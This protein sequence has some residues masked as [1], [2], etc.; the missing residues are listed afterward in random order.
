MT[1]NTYDGKYKIGKNLVEIFENTE[2]GFHDIISDYVP[3]PTGFRPLDSAISN[4]MRNGELVLLGGA[5][6]VGKTVA[7]LQI[8]RNIASLPD[9][10]AYYL[11]YEHPEVHLMHRLLCLESVDPTVGDMS[12]G[13]SLGE[14]Y[15]MMSTDE[16]RGLLSSGQPRALI[17]LFGRHPKAGPA[18][19]R[20]NAYAKRLIMLKATSRTTTLESIRQATR[21]LQDRTGGKVVVFIDYLQ[22]VAI[23]DEKSQNDDEKV[24]IITEGL[25]DIAMDLDV[26]VWA[27]VASDREGLKS[28]RMHL[29]H[30]R[31]SSALDYEAD[32][33]IIMNNKYSITSREHL[34]YNLA[35]VKKFRNWI[36]FTLEKNRAGKAFQNMEFELHGANFTFNQLGAF[37]PSAH[38][39][40]DEHVVNE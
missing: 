31:G 9:H 21:E 2:R 1:N 12:H 32:I 3:I 27:I 36:I 34:T 33:A 24:T 17:E 11:S 6:G 20:M 40:I 4:G 5:Q 39:L 37:V 29:Y 30:L 10:Y 26:P 35:E 16:A 14:I 25:K 22:K 18:L 13:L 15:K 8:A 38:R 7:S 23:G 28:K 19:R